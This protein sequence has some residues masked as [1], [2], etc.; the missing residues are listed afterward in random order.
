ME[1]VWEAYR[2]D[3]EESAPPSLDQTTTD[4]ATTYQL[5]TV[6]KISRIREKIGAVIDHE[7]RRI[8][9]EW[10]EHNREAESML[11]LRDVLCA[12]GGKEIVDRKIGE[13]NIERRRLLE[14]RE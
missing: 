7:F 3:Q 9:R 12:I 8:N 13:L 11:T 2:S 5:A 4:A 10:L 14:K 1:I 6:E